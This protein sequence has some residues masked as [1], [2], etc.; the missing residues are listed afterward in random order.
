[1]PKDKELDPV[2]K[3]LDAALRLLL[4]LQRDRDPEITIGDQILVL[5]DSGLT[6]GEAGKILGV[7]SNQIPSYLRSAKNK[8]LKAKLEKK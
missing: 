3:R 6:Q 7:P 5:E 2:S 8:K 1:M 4:D